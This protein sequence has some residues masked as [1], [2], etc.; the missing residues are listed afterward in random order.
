ARLLG[1]RLARELARR[2][3]ERDL[4]RA[5]Q[6][7]AAAHGLA[8]GADGLRR[9]GRR[10]DLA[11]GGHLGREPI[12]TPGGPTVRL[13]TTTSNRTP[14]GGRMPQPP[15]TLKRLTDVEDSAERFGLS[16]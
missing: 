13:S 1:G 6:Q 8:V 10:D 2:G 4:A 12:A 5:E 3:I 16:E 15:F 9:V 11:A 14:E 7:L